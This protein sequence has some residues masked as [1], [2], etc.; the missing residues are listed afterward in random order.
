MVRLLS[1]NLK[2]RKPLVR[3][4]LMTG[5]ILKTCGVQGCFLEKEEARRPIRKLLQ[6][7]L[8]RDDKNQPNGNEREE[9]TD[10]KDARKTRTKWEES[11]EER[12]LVCWVFSTHSVPT[13]PKATGSL[14]LFQQKR[15]KFGCHQPRGGT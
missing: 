6:F 9:E 2:C 12:V 14:A 10:V 8:A 5:G 15:H 13:T 3:S 11:R 7:I 1:A 4:D